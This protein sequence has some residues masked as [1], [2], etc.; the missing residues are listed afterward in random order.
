M[1]AAVF[2]FAG[3]QPARAGA[4]VGQAGAGSREFEEGGNSKGCVLVG[5]P[6][7]YERFGFRNLP[8][9]TLDGVPQE[10]WPCRWIRIRPRALWCFT[11]GS[12]Q[13]DSK[14]SPMPGFLN[15]GWQAGRKPGQGLVRWG[16]VCGNLKKVNTYLFTRTPLWAGDQEAEGEENASILRTEIGGWNACFLGGPGFYCW[17]LLGFLRRLRKTGGTV[18]G[19]EL[20]PSPTAGTLIGTRTSESQDQPCIPPQRGFPR[21]L[22]IPA[23][24]MGKTLPR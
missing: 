15:C 5:D 4:W 12:L 21:V 14:S 13:R 17:A 18:T 16:R 1:A 11:R 7:Y 8:D 22:G 23:P 2:G 10:Y 19:K 3:V 9:L 6:G 24:L 20:T